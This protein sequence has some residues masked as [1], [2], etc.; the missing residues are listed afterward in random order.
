MNPTAGS[1]TIDTR[2]QRHFCVFAMSFPG[3]E[4]LK[5]IYTSILQQHL[6]GPG[7]FAAPVQKFAPRIVDGAL[8]LQA[9]VTTVFLPTAIRFHYMFNLRDLSN[10]FQGTFRLH[11]TCES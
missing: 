9:K 8:A 6:A 10:I 3:N 4:A 1:F 11:C 5:T 7:N 2:L